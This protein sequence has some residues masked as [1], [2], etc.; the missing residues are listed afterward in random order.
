MRKKF[1]TDRQTD[2]KTHEG[3]TAYLS[4]FRSGATI[5]GN[6]LINELNQHIIVVLP[7][8]TGTTKSNDLNK[9]PLRL[10]IPFTVFHL[11]FQFYKN[12]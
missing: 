12:L 4:L 3:K 6:V 9:K 1:V 10:I 11:E 7:V 5:I 2:G 8:S